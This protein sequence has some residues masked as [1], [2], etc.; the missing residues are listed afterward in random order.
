[1]SYMEYP[2]IA[3]FD[4]TRFALAIKEVGS[5]VVLVTH[6]DGVYHCQRVDASE[7]K[8]RFTVCSETWTLGK[9]APTVEVYL[10]VLR[11]SSCEIT[12]EAHDL[13]K[14]MTMKAKQVFVTRKG[15]VVTA[16]PEDSDALQFDTSDLKD[17]TAASKQLEEFVSARNRGVFV[18][19]VLGL[20]NTPSKLKNGDKRIGKAIEVMLSQGAGQAAEAVGKPRLVK[21]GSVKKSVAKGNGAG[22]EKVKRVSVKQQLYDFFREGGKGSLATLTKRFESTEVSVRTAISDIRNEKYAPEGKPLNVKRDKEVYGV[23]GKA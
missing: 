10:K 22:K 6:A 11:Q 5:K 20:P 4:K 19:K 23:L 2:C 16:M 14:E 17:L 15:A 3:Q 18:A 7:F 21:P 13:I 9:V 1:M 8:R 12:Q